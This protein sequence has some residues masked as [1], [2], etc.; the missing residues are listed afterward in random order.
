MIDSDGTT[1]DDVVD[2]FPIDIPTTAAPVGIETVTST[3]NGT[4]GFATIELSF[5]VVCAPNYYGPHCLDFC[6]TENCTCHV[7]FTGEFCEMNIDDCFGVTCSENGLCVD[8]VNSFECN[9]NTGFTGSQCE[10]NIDDCV[11]VDCSGNGRCED[12]V[13]SFTCVCEPGFTGDLCNGTIESTMTC[14]TN[15]VHIT[16]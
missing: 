14:V 12:G 15:L 3:Y 7:G 5:R 11:G 8:G 4:F 2:W 1:Q 13:D 6:D 10:I 9:C 16:G